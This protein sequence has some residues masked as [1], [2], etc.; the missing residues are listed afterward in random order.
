[1]ITGSDFRAPTSTWWAAAF[2]AFVAGGLAKGVHWWAA[3]FTPPQLISA[4]S[5]L[6]PI[7]S[8]LAAVPLLG[9]SLTVAQFLA[10]LTA[11]ATTAWL[12]LSSSRS[13]SV[14]AHG[15]DDAVRRQVS[16][17]EDFDES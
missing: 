4:A 5:G 17:P 2:L 14:S 1:L 16:P 6:S 3:R 9:E 15:V 10:A 7:V 13:S 11:V 8:I 12:L